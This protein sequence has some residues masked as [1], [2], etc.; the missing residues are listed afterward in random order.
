MAF[1]L[2]FQQLTRECYPLHSPYTA[3]SIVLAKAAPTTVLAPAASSI[4]LANA[5]PAAL[6]ALAA[7]SIVLAKAAPSAFFALLARRGRHQAYTLCI[8][9]TRWGLLQT[10]LIFCDDAVVDR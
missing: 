1:V 7:D 2:V 4:V 8:F 5:A 3:D 9:Q 6:L 10:V